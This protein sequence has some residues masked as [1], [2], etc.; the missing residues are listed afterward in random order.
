MQVFDDGSGDDTFLTVRLTEATPATLLRDLVTA[1][2]STRTIDVVHGLR[3]HRPGG[4]WLSLDRVVAL[5]AQ[6]VWL[7]C[8]GRDTSIT[9]W[10]VAHHRVVLIDR[11]YHH[12]GSGANVLSRALFIDGAAVASAS[13]SDLEGPMGPDPRGVPL[14]EDLLA[15][16][17]D[18][19]A[20]FARSREALEPLDHFDP[21][22][23]VPP[24]GTP[25]AGAERWSERDDDDD[26]P[27]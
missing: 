23:L 18:G 4:G 3:F 16:I 8:S 17:G 26:I 14:N 5:A 15:R 25:G 21:L 2:A 19:A 9:E 22:A 20:L 27:F 7:E 11:A 6:V 12:D 13:A 10:L 1:F 24:S